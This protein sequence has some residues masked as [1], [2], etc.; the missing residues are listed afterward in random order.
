MSSIQLADLEQQQVRVKIQYI[1][2]DKSTVLQERKF[3][4]TIVKVD[5]EEGLVIK[6]DDKKEGIVVLP[7]AVDACAFAKDEVLAINWQVFRTQELRQ[8]GQH[9][10]WEWKPASA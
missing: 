9:E 6:A 10:W 3:S 8:D 7:P 2:L 5:Q 4:G 1:D